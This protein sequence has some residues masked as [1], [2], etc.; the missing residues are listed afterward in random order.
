[1]TDKLIKK[2][3]GNYKLTRIEVGDAG[4]FKASGMKFHTVHYEADGLGSVSVMSAKG[5]CGLMQ[6]DTLIVNP[7]YIDAPLFSYDSFKV[8][9]KITTVLE[10]YDTTLSSDFDIAKIEEIGALGSRF[11]DNI[12]NP[13]WFDYLR[14]GTPQNKKCKKNEMGECN[15]WVEKYFGA[16]L[17]ACHKAPECDESKKREKAA[18]YSDGLLKKGGPATDPVKKAIGEEKATF[19]FRNV[20]FATEK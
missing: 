5:F 20:L 2:I 13:Q 1:M 16:Y 12:P 19:F 14:L 6:I 17:D 8:C 15:K 4:D 9:G 7:F 11:A 10:M 3:N 18:I